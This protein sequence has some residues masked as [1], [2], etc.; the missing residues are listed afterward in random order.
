MS[1]RNDGE[2]TQDSPT[3]DGMMAT[4]CTPET[5]A[6]ADKLNSGG[7]DEVLAFTE[8]EPGYEDCCVHNYPITELGS[9][10]VYNVVRL[11]M[12]PDGGIARHHI[13]RGGSTYPDPD[14]N[15]D[16]R[17]K[18]YGEV[19]PKQLKIGETIDL[20]S[21]ENGGSAV[22]WSD[23]HYGQPSYLINPGR[24]INM[25]DGWETAR[26]MTRPRV[27]EI[28]ADGLVKAPGSD[29]AV[30]CLGAPGRV[31]KMEVSALKPCLHLKGYFLTAK[32]CTHRW[33]LLISKAIFQRVA[34]LRLPAW[35][36]IKGTSSSHIC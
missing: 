10:P 23:A 20:I 26:K 25:G 3:Y 8:L 34:S 17:L 15:P 16:G 2:P 22:A 13:H 12:Y 6:L 24:G 19:A 27:L 1:K 36:V 29:W 33:I 7:W 11:N 31:T 9:S 14:P 28:G 32:R 35:M 5:Q 21:A 4:C 18:I 30:I